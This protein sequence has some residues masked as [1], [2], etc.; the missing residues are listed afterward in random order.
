M[1]NISW[2]KYILNKQK[3]PPNELLIKALPHVMKKDAALDIGA[4]SLN[5]TNLLLDQ[6]FKHVEAVDNDRA[7]AK[8]AQTIKD[9]RFKFH[10]KDIKDIN[11]KKNF[12]DIVNAQYVLSY[13]SKKILV[14]TLVR[15]Q[16][17]LKLGGVFVGQFHGNRDSWNTPDDYRTYY[18][19][20]EVCSLFSIH[21]FKVLHLESE[22]EDTTSRL[23][24]P[25][26]KHLFHFIV[27][28]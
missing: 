23:G 25:K 20:E 12:Y 16:K 17:S 2:E 8:I 3:E 26:H 15:I 28:K 13:L 1:P 22:E 6:G 24:K 18:T 7:S 14:L 10:N 11:L 19:K 9:S 21:N 27:Q 5:D 4:G